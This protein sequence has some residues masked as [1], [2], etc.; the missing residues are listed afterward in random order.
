MTSRYRN[1][2]AP[3]EAEHPGE[4]PYTRGVSDVPRIWVMGQYAGFGTPEETNARFRSLLEAGLTGFSV[5]L[6]LPT[7]LG[8][9]SDHPRAAGEVGRVGVAI[10]SISDIE[11]LMDGIPL[12]EIAQVRTTANA[13][14]PVWLAWFVVLA[15]RRGIDPNSFGMFIQNDVL[16]EFIARGT[17][18]FPPA[19]SLK[20]S[21][22]VMQY[23]AEHLP[24]WVPLAM[25]GYH[26]RE[27][28][29]SASQEVAITFANAIAYL[30]AAVERGV[31]IDALAPTLFTFLS[32][33]PEVMP[34]LAKLR[35]ARQVWARLVRERYQPSNP[36]SEQLRIFAFTAG[37]SLTAQ[38]PMNNVIRTSMETVTAAMAS[39]QTLHVCAFDEA[40]GVPTE[41]A[42]HLALRTQQ[43][44]AYESGL[45]QMVDP[46]GGS[47][48]VEE[49]T[50]QAV[51][52][53]E[54]LLEQI[55][56]RGGAVK[57]IESGWFTHLIEEAAVQHASDVDRGERVVVGV[58]RWRV[59]PDPFQ[60]FR[61]DPRSEQAQVERLHRARAE[62]DAEVLES[63][64]LA[65][66]E[67]AE[68]GRNVVPAVIVAVEAEAT[69]GEIVGVLRAV[70]GTGTGVWA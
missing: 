36:A 45:T 6:D 41:N 12:E 7:Q 17:H 34:E 60:V 5:A 26:I 65:V 24:R 39:V 32:V 16:K 20:L 3:A 8:M 50:A 51:L 67:A 38:E 58:N 27:A 21:V 63:A 1:D 30:D 15:R 40:L 49:L 4:Y 13:I 59:P 31:D 33:G 9:D 11:I 56:E 14:G 25:S 70:Y 55:A 52:E 29:S 44:V 18:I 28:G 61:I 69:V 43:V 23:V 57:C 35:A 10:D 48:A 37:S 53:I 62:R 66:R 42:A 68:M 2:Y 46:M 19:A 64:L 54:G 22:D 47:W